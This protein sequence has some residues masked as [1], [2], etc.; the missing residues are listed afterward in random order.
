MNWPR[1]E[2]L[3][4]VGFAVTLV[5]AIAVVAT[6]LVSRR[7][8]SDQAPWEE[9]EEEEPRSTHMVAPPTLPAPSKAG[10]SRPVPQRH[11]RGSARQGSTHPTLPPGTSCDVFVTPA[12]P[13]SQHNCRVRISCGGRMIYGRDNGNRYY[14]YTNCTIGGSPSGELEIEALDPGV[15][16]QDGDP[17][18]QLR[19][20][21]GSL[22]VRDDDGRG[23]EWRLEIELTP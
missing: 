21:E 20:R 13:D 14:G 6:L 10:P 18:V 17:A 3:I 22:V 1:R 8:S 2:V 5:A 16:S 7:D 15:T 23:G 12:P 4:A 11:W 19:A 9:R